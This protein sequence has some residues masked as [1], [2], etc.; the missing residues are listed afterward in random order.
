MRFTPRKQHSKINLYSIT[1]LCTYIYLKG[2]V[3]PGK[4]GIESGTNR[5]VLT[6]AHNCRCFFFILPS[7]FKLH[8]NCF[9][10]KSIKIGCVCFDGVWKYLM[11]YRGP[12]F[13]AV[14]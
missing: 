10:V 13:L 12:G 11:I 3:Q 4:R 2:I 6:F 8:K 7:L 9:S 1:Y 5:N 14:G